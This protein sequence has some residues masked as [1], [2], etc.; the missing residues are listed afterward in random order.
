M[1]V[2]EKQQKQC[3]FCGTKKK[4]RTVYIIEGNIN[5]TTIN[6]CHSCYEKLNDSVTQLKIKKIRKTRILDRHLTYPF[7]DIIN[8][9]IPTFEGEKYKN[10]NGVQVSVIS[11]RYDVFKK[12]NV[13]CRCGL[14]GTYLASER[15]KGD[16]NYHFNLYGTDSGGDEVLFTKDHIIPKSKGGKNNLKNY[17]TMCTVCNELK[18]N[19]Q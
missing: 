5:N 4:K 12:S 16:E 14:E 3:D 15:H 18:G 6:M 8:Q 10:F 19:K 11:Q 9:I 13:C 2:L 7:N 1:N 17:Q